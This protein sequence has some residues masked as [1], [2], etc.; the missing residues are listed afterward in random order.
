MRTDYEVLMGNEEFRKLLA[1][2]TL[3][4]QAPAVIAELMAGNGVTKAELARRLGHSRA[5]VTQLLG[6]RTNMTI[7]TMAEVAYALGAE[8]RMS[9]EPAMGEASLVQG[10]ASHPFRFEHA[11]GLITPAA[12][13]HVLR[14]ASAGMAPA[15]SLPPIQGAEVLTAA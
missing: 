14:L 4:A 8:V 10:N 11:G 6:G 15:R 2:E 12:S 5:W 1:V 13:I 3:L 9:A 7:R